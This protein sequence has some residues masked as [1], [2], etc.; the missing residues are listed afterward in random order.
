MGKD[1]F[2]VGLT[3]SFESYYKTHMTTELVGWEKDAF[4]LTKAIYIQGQP[5][6]IKNNDTCTVRFLNEGVAYGFTSEV[7]TIQFFPFALMFLKYPAKFETLKIRVAPRYRTD[8]PA[9]LLD[10]SGAFIVDAI[11]LDISEGGCG[12]K[13]PIQQGKEPVPETGYAISFK[14]LD[15]EV[16]LGC[17]VKKLA[18][19]QDAYI[20]GMEFVNVS[21]Q[22][23]E[24]L[25]MLLDFMKKHVGG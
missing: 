18:M 15:R 11:L 13:V 4:V 10:A 24:M 3:L 1:I 8:L 14:I 16:G 2:E 9:R 19:A 20:L 23:K 12:L 5:A 25:T 22:Q 6:K 17:V 21:L 7:I